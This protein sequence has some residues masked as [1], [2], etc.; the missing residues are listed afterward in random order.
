M[1]GGLLQYYPLSPIL[2]ERTLLGL[3]TT[4]LP[5]VIT[6]NPLVIT[7]FMHFHVPCFH[8]FVRSQSS[9]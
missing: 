6:A 2:T 9:A 8:T 1:F 7:R 4:S 5:P 3:D